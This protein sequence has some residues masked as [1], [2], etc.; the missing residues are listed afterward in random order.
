MFTFSTF[1]AIVAIFASRARSIARLIE[2][3]QNG[4]PMAWTILAMIIAGVA[5]SLAFKWYHRGNQRT[6]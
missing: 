6:A 2:G 1:A 3:L 4:D 5:G